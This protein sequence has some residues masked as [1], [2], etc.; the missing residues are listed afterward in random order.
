MNWKDQPEAFWRERLTPEQYRILRE[1]GTERAFTGALHATKDAGRYHCAACGHVLFDSAAKFDSGSGWPS[2]W[3]V[4][5][6][7]QVTLRDDTNHGMR[8]IEVRC[9]Q[10]D[11]HLGHLFDDGP[12][13]T[14]Q[15]Y[16]INSAA[17]EFTS[18][19][20]GTT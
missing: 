1:S 3:D 16:C 18:G 11:S 14:G 12:V 20:K 4:V 13:P 2:F 10:C 19:K 7:G 5:Q 15:R 9:G 8:R 17:L 6:H